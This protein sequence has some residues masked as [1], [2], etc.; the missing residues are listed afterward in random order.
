LFFFI[1]GKP[2]T[3][4]F[5][6]ITTSI[7]LDTLFHLSV[8]LDSPKAK[9]IFIDQVVS[10]PWKN[11]PPNS[12]L[13]FMVSWMTHKIYAGKSTNEIELHSPNRR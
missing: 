7:Q 3:R 2:E 1:L 6:A 13:G 12:S 10:T 8:F 11:I 4:P 5:A 9:V